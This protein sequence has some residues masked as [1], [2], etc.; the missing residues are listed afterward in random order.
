MHFR[1]C[2]WITARSSIPGF[3]L[4]LISHHF[5]IV[6]AENFKV[7]GPDRPVV[8]VLGG[9]AELPCRLSPP[10][11]AEYM[12]VRWFRMGFDAVVHLYE[13]GVDQNK[14]Q[15]PEYDG[16]TELIRTHI[17]NGSVSL[18]I[19]NVGLKDEGRYTCFFRSHPTYEDATLELK[20]AGLGTAPVIS[21]TGYQDRGIRAVCESS[22]WYPEPDVTWRQ[23]DGQSLTS[24]SETE[25]REHN[26]LFNVTTSLLMRTSQ[27]GR[28]SCH[29]RNIILSQERE[30]GISISGAFFHRV[31]RWVVSLSILLMSVVIPCGLL[32]VLVLYHLRRK[33]S[34]RAKL[35]A[36][37][38]YLSAELEW[39]RCRSYAVHV[40]LDP[41][42][43][44][45]GLVVSEDQKS[46]RAG[47]TRK[48]LPDSPLRFEDSYLCVL[49][50][51]AFT[52]GRRYWEVEVG[53]GRRWELGVCRDCVCRKGWITPS[54]EE[55]YW[56]MGLWPEREYLV[57]T[58][59][60]I[61]LPLKESP[62]AMGIFLDY[63]A[64]EVS[65]YD[66]GNKSRLYTFSH[67]FTEPLRPLFCTYDKPLRIHPVPGWE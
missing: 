2:Y 61:Q 22:G 26:G 53:D 62:R 55:G 60:R 42:T 8:A 46:V 36:D 18:R 35:A 3:I 25:T 48:G 47:E 51:E 44:H 54:P 28:I 43:A 19:H 5:Q 64:G 32:V 9:D 4:L 29:I 30:S 63:E 10:L 59:P 11:S 15:I 58:S 38:K 12:Q 57:L 17:S 1:Q 27:Y 6:N 50:R 21:I 13:N 33:S 31:S 41:E 16:R 39:R 66:A 40:T 23:E 65:F 45:P 37:M 67:P 49:G 14:Q 20:V 52:S 24:L 34:E 7:I 56:A